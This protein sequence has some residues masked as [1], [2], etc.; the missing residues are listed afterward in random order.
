MAHDDKLMSLKKKIGDVVT[1]DEA[2]L[3]FGI[4]IIWKDEMRA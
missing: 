4:K 2:H 1:D 3:E